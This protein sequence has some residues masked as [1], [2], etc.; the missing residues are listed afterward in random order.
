MLCR[1]LPYDNVNQPEV[2][3]CP[4]PLEPPFHTPIPSHPSRLNYRALA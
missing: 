4:L 1:F 3:I 2:Y